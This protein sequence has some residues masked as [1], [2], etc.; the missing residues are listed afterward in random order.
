[1]SRSNQGIIRNELHDEVRQAQAQLIAG[2]EAR[3]LDGLTVYISAVA[4]AEIVNNKFI[5]IER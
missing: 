3:L 4:R 2:E 5:A 1:M